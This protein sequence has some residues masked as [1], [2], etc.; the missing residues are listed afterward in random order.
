MLNLQATNA[1][2]KERLR[3]LLTNII[4]PDNFERD[5][6]KYSRN[7]DLS[8]FAPSLGLGADLESNLIYAPGSFFPRSLDMNF[9]A[10]LDGTGTPVNIGEFG[11]RLE[12][13]EP[14]IAQ[15]FGPTGYFK[16]S[17]YNKILYDLI[18]FIKKN[19]SKI[20]EELDVLIRERRSLDSESL[21]SWFT[22]LYG[23]H[24]G[25]VQADVFARFMGQEISYGSLSKRLQ[26]INADTL[27]DDFSRYLIENL[28]KMKN[29]NLDSARATQL[30]VDYSFPTIQGTPLKMTM[31]A[32]VVAGI[33]LKTNLNGASSEGN[34]GERFKIL[35]T[36]SVKAHSF[37]GYD[38]YMSRN[39]IKMNATVSSSNGL[40]VKVRSGREMEIEVD[41]PEKMEVI[42][43]QSEAFLIKGKKDMPDTKVLPPSMQDPRIRKQACLTPLE[44]VFGLKMCYH[45]DVPDVVRADFLPLGAPILARVSINKT[46]PSIKGY[47]IAVTTGT[48]NQA[49]KYSCKVSVVGSA[50]P[51]EANVE[52]LQ[53]KESDSYMAS[54]KLQ[55]PVYS[56]DAKVLFIN[57]PEY[58]SVQTD[59]ALRTERSDFSK[60]IKV[61]IKISSEGDAKKYETNIFASPSGQMSDESK[62]FTAQLM[63][64]VRA[65]WVMVDVSAKTENAL[66]Q[67]FPLRLEGKSRIG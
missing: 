53:K 39:G 15:L 57:K 67:Y 35:P 40:A 20:Q 1:P 25:P 14:I 28:M 8:Y 46:E 44:R 66:M 38:A 11:G 60:A 10:A 63:K 23:P 5:L 13:L 36:L 47:K 3:S 56:G 33:Q 30:G 50:S 9:T 21:K 7:I 51:K 49:K 48:E 27:I 17:S 42:K 12:G 61:D 32:I 29:L 65:P 4:I 22:K 43:L 16:K 41:L 37:I 19:W 34:A 18:S 45:F 55:S 26:D 59:I 58:K 52:V 31:E 64:R 54:I 2:D 6:R 24:S 62:I